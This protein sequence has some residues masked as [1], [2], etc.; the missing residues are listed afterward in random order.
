VI[1]ASATDNDSSVV[2]YEA[3]RRL[4]YVALTRSKNRLMVWFSGKPHATITEARI[5]IENQF[6]QASE[7]F[8]KGN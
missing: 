8:L 6:A 1:D 7:V 5:P 4:M 2:N 3:E